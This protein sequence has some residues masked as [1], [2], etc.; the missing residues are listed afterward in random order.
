MSSIVVKVL[1]N[2]ISKVAT[3]FIE[4]VYHINS[5]AKRKEPPHIVAK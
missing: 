5:T 4:R 2:T 3:N 1:L